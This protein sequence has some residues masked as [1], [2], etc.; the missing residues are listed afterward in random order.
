MRVEITAKV[1][2]ASPE[3]RKTKQ[4]AAN[5]AML[6]VSEPRRGCPDR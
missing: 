5:V 4:K 3:P 6:Y 1:A 2:D